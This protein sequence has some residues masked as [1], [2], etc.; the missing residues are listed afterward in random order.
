V[1][2]PEPRLLLDANVL[3]SPVLRDTLLRAAE[4]HLFRPLWSDE[5]LSELVRTIPAKRT[6][7]QPD[8][9]NYLVARMRAAFP[10][11]TITGY[12]A[13][14]PSLTN[15]PGDRHVLAA[16]IHGKVTGIVTWNRRHFLP[17][18]ERDYG[19]SILTPDALLRQLWG[20]D[21]SIMH[22]LLI[23]Q[24]ADLRPPQSLASILRSLERSGVAGFVE[25]VR[26]A[27]DQR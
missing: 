6:G 1:T 26:A 4:L 14:L 5:I 7:V 23:D 12:S 18:A 9:L 8:R 20:S 17:V 25:L 11:A 21:S 10:D 24:G 22:Q 27:I 19:I 2:T 15:H 16:A 13:I 3:W